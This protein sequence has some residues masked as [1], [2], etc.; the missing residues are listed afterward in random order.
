MAI[1]LQAKKLF[2]LIHLHLC[3][4]STHYILIF[5]YKLNIQP[6]SSQ[7]ACACLRWWWDIDRPYLLPI[8]FTRL[9][10]SSPLPAFAVNGGSFTYTHSSGQ[11]N[12]RRRTCLLTCCAY[13]SLAIREAAAALGLSRKSSSMSYSWA[14][15]TLSRL[16]FSAIVISFGRNLGGFQW[17]LDSRGLSSCAMHLYVVTLGDW[18]HRTVIVSLLAFDIVSQ[19]RNH[20]FVA[21]F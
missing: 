15:S 21:P 8:L 3:Y 19:T 1:N 5:G 14:W 10:Q 20:R 17:E 16:P 4:T 18:L 7:S 2:R 13:D 11:N 9:S 12:G 6:E